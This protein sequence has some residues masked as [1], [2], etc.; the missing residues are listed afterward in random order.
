MRFGSVKSGSLAEILFRM[1]FVLVCLCVETA[2][3]ERVIIF[4]WNVIHATHPRHHF[5]SGVY[6]RRR[7]SWD[8]AHWCIVFLATSDLRWHR[9]WQGFSELWK[10]SSTGVVLIILFFTIPSLFCVRDI[11]LN[12]L[13][14]ITDQMAYT[15]SAIVWLLCICDF[16]FF[17]LFMSSNSIRSV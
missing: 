10:V 13:N 6:K 15:V 14:K 7:G 1:N 9:E 2:V 11:C 3:L 4:E 5:L 17:Y 8:W 16:Q 12:E